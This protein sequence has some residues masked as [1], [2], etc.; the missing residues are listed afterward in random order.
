MFWGI[1]TSVLSAINTMVYKKLLVLNA[2]N[3]ISPMGLYGYMCLLVV[4]MVGVFHIIS[5]EYIP[6][7]FKALEEFP[8]I[9]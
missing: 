5:P 8:W 7:S 3:G 6:L 4:I 2:K 9:L 1:V